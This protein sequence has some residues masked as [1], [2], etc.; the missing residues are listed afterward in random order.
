MASSIPSSKNGCFNMDENPSS[1]PSLCSGNRTTNLR[2]RSFASG[3][4]I[5]SRIFY[6]MP[7]STSVLNCSFT[8]DDVFIGISIPKWCLPCQKFIDQHSK[9]IVIKFIRVSCLFM[10]FWRHCMGCSTNGE[11]SVSINFFS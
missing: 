10:S 7:C 2:T 8:F 11:G 1:I 4:A 5:E 9:T 6:V 3:F